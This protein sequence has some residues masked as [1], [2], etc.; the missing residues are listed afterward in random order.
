MQLPSGILSSTMTTSN[1]GISRRPPIKM[2]AAQ[3]RPG[4]AVQ[5]PNS[6]GRTNLIY[7]PFATRLPISGRRVRGRPPVS[8]F[9]PDPRM[10]I[11]R[12]GKGCG[13]YQ[14]ALYPTLSAS[15][16]QHPATTSQPRQRE[17]PSRTRT[18]LAVGPA[19][20]DSSPTWR[21][22]SQCGLHLAAS[23][24]LGTNTGA[25]QQGSAAAMLPLK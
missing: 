2:P 7:D 3:S 16:N 6:L 11:T 19:N 22:V 12:R 10:A 13:C 4:S 14:S 20:Q 21:P 25:T 9:R 5:P 1:S 18:K 17:F 15:P 23:R 8:P 24:V